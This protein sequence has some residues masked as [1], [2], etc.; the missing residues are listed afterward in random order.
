MKDETFGEKFRKL[1]DG[2]LTPQES[3]NFRHGHTF[4]GV[5]LKIT[6]VRPAYEITSEDLRKFLIEAVSLSE[7]TDIQIYFKKPVPLVLSDEYLTKKFNSALDE[8]FDSLFIPITIN[9]QCTP[10]GPGYLRM[11]LFGKDDLPVEPGIEPV[12]NTLRM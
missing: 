8:L 5:T 1:R 6:F 10:S 12:S 11:H 4:M 9:I 2:K 3:W 7:P